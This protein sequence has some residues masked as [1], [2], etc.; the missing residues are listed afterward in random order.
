MVLSNRDPRAEATPLLNLVPG[1]TAP[2][3]H[4]PNSENLAYS[5]KAVTKPLRRT[6]S[7]FVRHFF[8]VSLCGRATLCRGCS[9]F[10]TYI[11]APA[12]DT[13]GAGACG[14]LDLRTTRSCV[15]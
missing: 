12:A 1:P 6:D 9:A 4:I 2:C 14:L 8:G 10:G 13:F 5:A 7:I 11:P 15:R 3:I